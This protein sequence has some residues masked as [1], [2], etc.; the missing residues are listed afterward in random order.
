M[1][2]AKIGRITPA[3]VVTEFEARPRRRMQLLHPHRHRAAARATSSTSPP[4][5]TYLDAR[6]TCRRW[7]SSRRSRCPTAARSAASLAVHG[8]VVCITD[9]NNHVV[10]RYDTTSG[11]FDFVRGRYPPTSRST[12]PG[13]AWFTETQG[14]RLTSART[15]HDRRASPARSSPNRH[16]DGGPCDRRRPVDGK[17]WFARTVHPAGRAQAVGCLDPADGNDVTVFAGGQH[18]AQRHRRRTRRHD[19]VHART[20]KGN[21]ASVT[22]AGVITQ[23]KTVNGQPA[24]GITVAPDGNRGTPCGRRTRSPRRSRYPALRES[25]SDSRTLKRGR[26]QRGPTKGSP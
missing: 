12:R 18:R 8:D 7:P 16:D 17:V 26:D 25:I 21:V 11:T 23:G 6:S 4:T 19:L 22:N 13:N 14:P 2:P 9:F 20:T 1:R 24:A 3:G 15:S 10:W 5:T